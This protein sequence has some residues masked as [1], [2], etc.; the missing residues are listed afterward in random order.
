[1][2]AHGAVLVL[3]KPWIDAGVMVLMRTGKFL[4]EIA[5]FEVVMAYGTA[6]GLDLM[7]IAANLDCLHPFYLFHSEAPGD[8]P[9][10]LTQSKQLLIAHLVRVDRVS[11]A[12]FNS[13]LQEY[14]LFIDFIHHLLCENSLVSSLVSFCSLF[15]LFLQLDSY[16]LGKQV[17]VVLDGF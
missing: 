5:H 1:L 6:L 13:L 12:L 3:L 2:L 7:V 17:L 11:L 8:T 14:L 4:R 9:Q 16:H 15:F 10:F